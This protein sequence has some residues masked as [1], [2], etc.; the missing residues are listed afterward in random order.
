MGLVAAVALATSVAWG[1]SPVSTDYRS[2]I[3][4][5]ESDSR[6]AA[7]ERAVQLVPRDATVAA[8]YNLITHLTHRRGAYQF[9]EP[10]RLFAWGINGEGM[11]DP[12]GVEWLAIDRTV[13][14]DEDRQLVDQLLDFTFTPV[15]ERNDVVVARRG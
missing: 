11:H 8:S 13:L 12:K 3:W 14:N 15:Y 2:G 6:L 5:L 10:W 9:P 1:P 4:P 7:Q